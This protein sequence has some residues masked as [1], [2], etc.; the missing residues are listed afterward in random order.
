MIHSNNGFSLGSRANHEIERNH[1]RKHHKDDRKHERLG[2]EEEQ[3]RTPNFSV[4]S[5]SMQAMKD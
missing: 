3:Q 2:G 4:L 1:G 5:P